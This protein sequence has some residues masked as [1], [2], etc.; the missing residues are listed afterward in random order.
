[1][2]RSASFKVSTPNDIAFTCGAR[3]GALHRSENRT[4]ALV[5]LK[6]YVS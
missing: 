2:R 1:M 4:A 3:P 5:L 6:L